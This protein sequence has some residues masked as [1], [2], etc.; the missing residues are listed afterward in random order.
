MKIMLHGGPRDGESH[1]IEWS[2]L[3][4]AIRF[5]V[6]DG[7]MA[8]PEI[9]KNYRPFDPAWGAIISEHLYRLGDPPHYHYEA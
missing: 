9:P 8:E 4:E 6:I 3:P 1:E 5:P 7:L 2:E